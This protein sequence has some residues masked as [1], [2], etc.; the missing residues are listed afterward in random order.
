ME[1]SENPPVAIQ[2]IA[3]IA[4][5]VQN[6][7]EAKTFYRDALELKFLFDAG[8]MSF[9]QCGPVRL[10]IGEAERSSVSEG[11]IVYFRVPDLAAA[12]QTL[13]SRGVVF[14]RQPHLV[15]R[16]KSHDL[17]MAFLKDPAGNTLGLMSEVA[18]PVEK[19]IKNDS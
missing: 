10:M 5:T 11:T 14:T 2:E 1:A 3:Q 19:R 7:E 9:F 16:M 6:L 17:W 18:R 15:A 8:T 13:S 12:A 4:F